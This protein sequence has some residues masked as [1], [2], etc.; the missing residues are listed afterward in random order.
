MQDFG[1]MGTGYGMKKRSKVPMIFVLVLLI[2]AV[3]LGGFIF[4]QMSKPRFIFD[5]VI[6][7]VTKINEVKEFSTMKVDTNLGFSITGESV[8]D[9]E[10]INFV[11]DSEL[12]FNVEIDKAKK[13]EIVGIK[14]TNVEDELINARLKLDG[15][16][17]KAYM[18][19]G[20]IFDKIIE[21]D[22]ELS[23]DSFDIFESTELTLGQKINAKVASEILGKEIKTQLKDEFFETEKVSVD[24]V[25][26]TKN[27]L[28]MTGVQFVQIIKN[29]ST[30]LAAN[31]EFLGCFEEREKIKENLT[32]MVNSLEEAE[33]DDEIN[34]EISCYTT[35]FVPEIK[36]VEMIF[37]DG[38]EKIAVECKKEND[39][40][41]SYKTFV[42]GDEE[43]S[44]KVKV[45]L[46]EKNYLFEI[47]TVEDEVEFTMNLSGSVVYDEPLSK[48]NVS[49]AVKLDELT[50][51]DSLELANN[52]KNSKLYEA[53][54]A[55]LI[56]NE[57]DAMTDA[58]LEDALK[59][60]SDFD[61]MNTTT[62]DEEIFEPTENPIQP[63]N[64]EQISEAENSKNV[65]KTYNDQILKFNIPEGYE[66]YSYD[67]EAYKLFEKKLDD[68]YLD[69]DVSIDYS[70]MD[71]YVGNVKKQMSD[72]EN[73]GDYAN[74][75]LTEQDI[76][77][78]GNSFKRMIYEYDYV[79][80]NGETNPKVDVYIAHEVDSENLYVVEISG[81]ENIS[82]QELVPFLLIEK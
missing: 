57:Y 76:E 74:M 4:L 16:S 8:E 28:K 82:D 55:M 2:I 27:I 3:V 71:E 24:G 66:C 21:L 61:D 38:V 56:F 19:L 11:N 23:S 36:N 12:G 9:N 43:F 33:A 17:K 34:I 10:I 67:S 37:D 14:L 46:D 70:T 51:Q 41:I 53:I 15:N 48:L 75:Q 45:V 62:D 52:F 72:R 59:D 54:E 44:G 65:L 18:D 29:V 58:S 7:A 35:G 40:Y 5:K 13:Q 64:F 81:P 26:M 79:Y 1:E 50:M 78:N 31:E 30:N 68:D 42:D 25:K 39:G 77:V 73:Q 60:K 6:D 47:T 80:S 69:V 49:S 20:E 63:P 32:E 22:D